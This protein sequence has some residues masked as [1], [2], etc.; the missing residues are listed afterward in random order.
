MSEARSQKPEAR[1]QKV[2]A[3]SQKTE[4][5]R[6]KVESRWGPLCN[7]YR[8]VNFFHLLSCNDLSLKNN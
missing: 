6:Q 1:G 5:R 3:R 2:E 7:Q 8:G 4:A